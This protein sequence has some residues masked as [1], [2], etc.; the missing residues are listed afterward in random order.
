MSNLKSWCGLRIHLRP[1]KVPAKCGMCTRSKQQE[2]P[3]TDEEETALV[4]QARRRIQGRRIGAHRFY[5][6]RLAFDKTQAKGAFKV[7]ADEV[8][9]HLECGRHSRPTTSRSCF[10][11]WVRRRT[12]GE[13]RVSLTANQ[14]CSPA[15]AFDDIQDGPSSAQNQ[16]KQRVEWQ[17]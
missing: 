12:S 16:L 15:S 11:Y 5:Q 9:R 10:S 13:V 8:A 6:F 14:Q 1:G 3:L 7:M 4:E 17:A 2:P